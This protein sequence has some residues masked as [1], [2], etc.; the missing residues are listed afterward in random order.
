MFSLRSVVLALGPALLVGTSY[1]VARPA[2]VPAIEFA[3]GPPAIPAR[4]PIAHDADA[5]LGI[6]CRQL[7]DSLRPRLGPECCVVAR[8]PY[9]LGGNLSEDQL[10]RL[11]RDVIHPTES[12]LSICYFDTR[13]DEPITVL[14]FSDDQAYR[15]AAHRFDA[16]DA[17]GY[18][19]YYVRA[20]RR[21]M[22]NA[23]TGYGTLGHE[24]TH[25]LAHF[26]CPSLPGWF[27]EGLAALHEQCDF[28]EDG[29]RLVGR[30]NWRGRILKEELGAGRA[31]PLES[32]V[33]GGN[34]RPER[35]AADYAQARYL[36]LYLQERQLLAHFY[37]KLRRNV[38]DDP[39]GLN[40]LRELL[41]VSRLDEIEPSFRVWLAET[42]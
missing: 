28:S 19:G 15:E 29:L 7:A 38:A 3:S 5:G 25:A 9:V 14:L 12:A 34:L 23:A 18:Y 42:P 2:V 8:P 1:W 36:C 4:P 10:A 31:T 24:L 21:V 22:V 16:R 6:A 30:P 17:A 33:S 39:T 32:L 26:D 20:E 37:R 35:E 11:H 27:D 40:T 41:Q 13:P